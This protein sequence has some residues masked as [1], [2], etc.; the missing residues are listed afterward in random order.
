VE[1]ERGICGVRNSLI[2]DLSGVLGEGRFKKILRIGKIF[3]H[4][5]A[6]RGRMVLVRLI[7]AE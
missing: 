4:F 3:V 7:L 6:G 2:L 1:S 5:V